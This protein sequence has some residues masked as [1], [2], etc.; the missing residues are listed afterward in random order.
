MEVE[1]NTLYFQQHFR[2]YCLS[3]IVVLEAYVSLKSPLSNI[4]SLS[5]FRF[6]EL[7]HPTR[8]EPRMRHFSKLTLQGGQSPV[9]PVSLQSQILESTIKHLYFSKHLYQRKR[10]TIETL[11]PM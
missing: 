11:A 4:L 3:K 1:I 2:C 7:N 9:L 10:E 6:L 8:Q 5:V